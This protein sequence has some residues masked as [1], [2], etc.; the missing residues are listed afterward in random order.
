MTALTALQRPRLVL[1]HGWAQH[2]GIWQVW[3]DRLAPIADMT[4]VD[5]PG[6]GGKPWKNAIRSLDALADSV[7]PALE[8][9]AALCGWS[10]GGMIAM[11]LARRHPLRVTRLVLC[12]TTPRF[13]AGHDWIHAVQPSLVEGFRRRVSENPERVLRDFL[14]LQLRGESDSR[15][16]LTLLR[17]ALTEQNRP[18]AAALEFTLSLLA[19]TDLRDELA[20][21][22]PPTLV[23]AS[24]ADAI[25]PL[26]AGEYLARQLPD[27]RLLTVTG[28]GHAGF[29]SRPE[30]L[31]PGID[32]FLGGDSV[33]E[34]AS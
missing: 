15:Q 20:A 26:A 9:P 21:I 23:I 25:T 5:L 28:C 29:L 8:Q 24:D 10:L 6:H 1:I 27:A 22:A 14:S 34:M 30:R 19:Q 16:T 18:R 17:S 11:N 33:Q 3:R 12:N 31:S 2:A 32:E 4:A 13:V 7:L